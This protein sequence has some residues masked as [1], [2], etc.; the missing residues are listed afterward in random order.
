MSGLAS[1]EVYKV[2]ID[3]TNV[4]IVNVPGERVIPDEEDLFSVYIQKDGDTTRTT[5]FE[6]VPSD[7]LLNTFDEFTTRYPDDNI[8]KLYL[9]GNSLTGEVLFDDFYLS[10]T[11]LLATTPIGAGY[12]GP[13]PTIQIVK[14]GGQWQILFQG[15]LL[16]ATSVTGQ[17]TEVTGATSPYPI[18]TTGEKKFYRAV[19]N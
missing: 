15:K 3:V 5:L 7:R 13:P 11:G 18:T 12:G 8:N 4:P 19:C 16:E 17:W 10:K 14:S 6:N 2:W 9:F 1:N